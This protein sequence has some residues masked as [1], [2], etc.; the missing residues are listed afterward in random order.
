MQNLRTRQEKISKKWTTLLLAVTLS[1]SVIFW[2]SC[3]KKYVVIPDAM[4]P[5]QM[6][7]GNYE[8][9]PGFIRMMYETAN[10]LND[11]LKNCRNLKQAS[12]K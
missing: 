7:N 3:G 12:L 10:I 8:V 4:Q 5:V 2:T 1:A 11:E 6:E 9:T